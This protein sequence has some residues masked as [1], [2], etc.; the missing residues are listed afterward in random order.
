MAVDQPNTGSFKKLGAILPSL[1]A[2]IGIFVILA[3]LKLP[4]NTFL[5]REIHNAGHTP[6]FGAMSL[7]VLRILLVVSR[8]P[9]ATRLSTYGLAAAITIGLGALV[10]I[11]QIAGPGDAD[12]L[13][14][15]RDICG[16][17][18]FLLIASVWDRRLNSSIGAGRYKYRLVAL[19]IAVAILILALAPV[20]SWAV[21]YYRRERAFPMI[22]AFDSAPEMKFVNTQDASIE[23]VPP[24]KE[25]S[26]TEGSAGK[27]TLHEGRFPG[28]VISEVYPD[29]RSYNFFTFNIF[30]PADKPVKL[31]LRI[32]DMR[33]NDE[34]RD[35]FN[36]AIIINPG[37]NTYKI[38]LD[39]V[40]N[41]PAS[42]DMDMNA[43]GSV[44]IFGNPSVAGLTFYLDNI[45]L[46]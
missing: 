26:D 44:I 15:I 27:L 19:S 34:Y 32:D 6:L 43:M 46:E 9:T 2:I 18:S 22:L 24:P 20:G 41:A 29:W 38:S 37:A 28:L 30:S 5:W 16:V 31:W 4:Y 23:R 35:R 40:K 7:F 3:T 13:D 8:Q 45:R 11:A 36:D 12:I 25:W 33:H 1:L 21:A 17:I 10:E 14:W 39:R 42:R